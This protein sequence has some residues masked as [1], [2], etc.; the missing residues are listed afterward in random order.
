MDSPGEEENIVVVLKMVDEVSLN[1]SVI[2]E[3]FN[4]TFLEVE[5]LLQ[6]IFIID[7]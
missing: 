6:D 4:V 3:F 5:N 7:E 2:G 1:Y